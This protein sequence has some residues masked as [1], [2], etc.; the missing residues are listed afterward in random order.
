MSD[1]L[2]SVNESL[3]KLRSIETYG[4]NIWQWQC[5]HSDLWSICD[6]SKGERFGLAT[7]RWA[8]LYCADCGVYA[9]MLRID[10]PETAFTVRIDH[11]VYPHLE[12]END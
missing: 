5:T 3:R 4:L 12:A 2:Y 11:W 9:R 1:W 6:R 8:Y 10:G 7:V